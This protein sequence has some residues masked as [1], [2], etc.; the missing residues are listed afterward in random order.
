MAVVACKNFY[1]I[2][3]IV[4][5]VPDHATTALFPDFYRFFKK[6]VRN[7]CASNGKPIKCLMGHRRR[8]SLASQM[9]MA[10][11][12]LFAREGSRIITLKSTPCRS[13][14][15]SQ[16]NHVNEREEDFAAEWSSERRARCRR[17]QSF[18]LIRISRNPGVL[19]FHDG[20]NY[21]K[22]TTFASANLLTVALKHEEHEVVRVLS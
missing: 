12:S 2:A 19:V 13:L 15:L 3:A 17:T 1:F 11:S 21:N 14:A 4:S 5:G 7:P 6:P 9:E 8:G 22:I 18:A 20:W 16:T 10:P